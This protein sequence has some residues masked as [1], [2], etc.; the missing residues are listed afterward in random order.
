MQRAFD[1]GYRFGRP[2]YVPKLMKNSLEKILLTQILG[3]KKSSFQL[4]LKI[5]SNLTLRH[6]CFLKKQSQFTLVRFEHWYWFYLNNFRLEVINP[7]NIQ[8][9]LKDC[10]KI[11]VELFPA[12]F[13]FHVTKNGMP[14]LT[15]GY[16]TVIIFLISSMNSLME[17]ISWESILLRDFWSIKKQWR[18]QCYGKKRFT[19]KPCQYKFF[20]SIKQHS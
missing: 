15:P 2:N 5:A 7:R 16:A 4:Y 10:L 17:D 1:A 3:E 13:N 18:L 11:N 14:K 8:A 12:S 19:G 20:Y 6:L 9:R